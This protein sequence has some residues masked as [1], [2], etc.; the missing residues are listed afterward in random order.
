MPRKTLSEYETLLADAQE[1]LRLFNAER[2]DL[3]VYEVSVQI[4]K[5]MNEIDIDLM[6]REI[7]ACED[8]LSR[9]RKY[10]KETI[11]RVV[12]D[13]EE[14]NRCRNLVDAEI[15]RCDQIIDD[16][17]APTDQEFAA[18]RLL[19]IMCELR[20]AIKGAKPASYEKE[21]L[22]NYLESRRQERE[23]AL[24]NVKIG[25]EALSRI[26][27]KVKQESLV[28]E[29]WLTEQKEVI[30]QIEAQKVVERPRQHT[31]QPT[32]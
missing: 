20:Q 5:H 15:S 27:E 3:E 19:S 8:D 4:H 26:I 11:G 17:A 16:R 29:A 22:Q 23:V 10:I 9:E 24:G 28:D 2:Q 31:L 18:R 32:R 6:K 30:R 25:N 7:L 13:G 21:E 12:L 1:D 14:L